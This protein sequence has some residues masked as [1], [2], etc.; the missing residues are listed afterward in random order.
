[1]AAREGPL[2]FDLDQV[3]LA[4]LEVSDVAAVE[5]SPPP[6]PQAVNL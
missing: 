1:M 3:V 6:W 2:A 5:S 4:K